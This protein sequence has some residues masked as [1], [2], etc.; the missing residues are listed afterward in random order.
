MDLLVIGGTEFVGRHLVQAA[1]AAGHEV[2]IF[3][4]GI[5]SPGLFPDVE[6]LLGDRDGGLDALRDRNWKAV[7]DTCGYVPRVVRGSAEALDRSARHYTFVSSMSVYADPAASRIDESSDVGRLED[8][9]SEDVDEHYGPLKASCEAEVLRVFGDRTLVT[10]CGLI[11]GP[12]DRADRFLY[13]V[14]RVSRG[15]EV[16]AP[17]R[18]DYP[19][20]LIDARDLGEWIVRM[21][22]ASTGGTYNVTGPSS[23]LTMREL[24]ETCRCVSGSDASFTWVDEVFLLEA[25]VKPWDG[26]P[27]WLGPEFVGLTSMDVSGAV[28][29]G[30][31]FRPI[32][33]TVRD[34]LEWDRS[35]P[36]EEP[37]AAGLSAE[38]ESE[39][40]RAWA[41]RG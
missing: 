11:V 36:H 37:L 41:T 6:E 25:G 39:L 31:A 5:T 24:L 32:A 27:Y 1:L 21:A 23:P 17:C 30:L 19:V 2:T 15:G 9:A 14:R 7:V 3:H 35:R 33:D 16:L 4:R 40:L 12:F 13:W 26:L 20:Q 18:P 22:E 38:R 28:G 29:A 8:A 10:R 34:V